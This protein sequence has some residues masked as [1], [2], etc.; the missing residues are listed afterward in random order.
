MKTGK[1]DKRVILRYVLFQ[2]PGIFIVLAAVLLLLYFTEWPD[3]IVWSIPGIW[4][5]KEIVLFFFVWP[6]Y[7]PPGKE[8]DPLVGESG[9]V[10]KTCGPEG[11]VEIHGVPW[12]AIAAGDR[13]KIPKGLM[14]RVCERE[15]LTLFVR[16]GDE[17]RTINHHTGRHEIASNQGSDM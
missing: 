17:S 8:T 4:I 11:I 7:R 1:P 12:R 2:L 9:P 6:A 15:G 5:I 16:S 14:A 3:G 10:V 13:K